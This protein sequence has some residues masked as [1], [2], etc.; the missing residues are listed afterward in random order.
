MDV[1]SLISPFSGHAVLKHEDGM[2]IEGVNIG[3]FKIKTAISNMLAS[4]VTCP[5]TYADNGCSGLLAG[6]LN[7]M[8]G[9]GTD[10]DS[11]N[12]PCSLLRALGAVSEQLKLQ[13][14]RTSETNEL[15]TARNRLLTENNELLAETIKLLGDKPLGTNRL[16]L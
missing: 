1:H 10:R 6:A 9:T 15:R 14:Q 8:E 7:Y 5:D 3:E 4:A 13:R 12:H 16:L 11:D 2:R